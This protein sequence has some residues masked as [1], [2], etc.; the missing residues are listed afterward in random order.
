[1]KVRNA[2]I[3][4]FISII[5]IGLIKKVSRNQIKIESKFYKLYKKNFENNIID[6][7]EENND[8]KEIIE[9]E[10]KKLVNEINYIKKLNIY[11][12]KKLLFEN[13][14]NNII[15]IENLDE[16]LE[17]IIHQKI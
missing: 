11:L 7:N 10:N 3:L 15:N 1:M 2:K 17:K 4:K 6:L 9:E 12:D 16:I 14:N 5:G 8:E 13:E